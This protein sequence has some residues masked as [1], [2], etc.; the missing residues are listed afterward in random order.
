MSQNKRMDGF[1][2]ISKTIKGYGVTHVFYVEAMLRMAMRHLGETGVNKIMA[3]SENAAAYMADGYARMSKKPSICMSQSIGSANLAGGIHEAWLANSPVIALTGKKTPV[4]QY[5]GSYQEA[6]HRLLYEGITK[7]NADII[8]SEQLPVVLRQ[9][10]RSAVTSKPRPVH[11]D[12]ANHTGRT[13]ELG[14]VFENVYVEEQYT[15][16]PAFRPAAEVHLVEQAAKEIFSSD[17]PVL[18]VGRGATISEAGPEI[19]Q[20]AKKAQIPIVTSPDG[21]AL[22]DESDELWCGIVGSYGMDCAN[23]VVKNADLVIFIGTQAGDQTTFDWKVPAVDTRVIQID[24]DPSELGKNYP[25][26][27]GLFGDAKIVTQQLASNIVSQTRPSWL[28]TAKAFVTETLNNYEVK[29][30][31]NSTPIRPER[32]CA[33]ISKALPDNAVLVADTGYSAVWSSTMIR[34]KSSQKYFRA[35]GSLGWSFPA[36]LGIKCAAGD[37]PVICFSGDG[38]FYYHLNEM[39]TAVRNNIPTV[40]IIN[41]NNALVQ[42]RPDLSLVYKDALDKIDVCYCYPNNDFAD[43]AKSYG[44]WYKNVVTPEDV[45]PAIKEALASG[46]PAIINVVTDRTADVPNAL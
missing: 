5:R 20:L 2:F 28:T 31:S 32:L 14:S 29:Q 3:H 45:G 11:A 38:A 17:R 24:I 39:E 43:I 34:M 8:Q 30:A 36:S 15:K 23:K 1:E 6:D 18:V 10:F 44:C 22:I 25:N 16:Y 4:Y 26:S 13:V 19:L 42:C 21:K 46:K 37:L 12:L 41:N 27:I 7:F 9:L 35:A 40:T 33:E